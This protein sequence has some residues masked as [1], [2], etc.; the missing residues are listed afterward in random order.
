[1]SRF[2]LRL[3]LVRPKSSLVLLLAS[4]TTSQSHLKAVFLCAIIWGAVNPDLLSDY[5]GTTL[6]TGLADQ[7]ANV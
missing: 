4:L 5:V 2:K 7:S 3:V 1:M 6:S